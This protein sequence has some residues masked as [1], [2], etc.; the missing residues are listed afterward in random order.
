MTNDKIFSERDLRRFNG[1]DGDMFIAF[2]GIVYDV[3]SCPH[4][5][6]G[7]HQGLHFPGQD[8]TSELTDAPHGEEVF[9]RP[10]V[11]QVGSL[12]FTKDELTQ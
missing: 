2:R 6:T 9:Q 7:L 12:A 11:K 5:R 4:W 8:L 1:D 3:T 10:T